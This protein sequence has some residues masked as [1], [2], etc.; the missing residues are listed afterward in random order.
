VS[1]ELISFIREIA[2]LIGEALH[3]FNTEEALH[4]NYAVQNVINALLRL[5]DEDLPLQDILDRALDLI[6]SFHDSSI[7]PRGCIFVLKQDQN[8]L[9]MRAQ[10]GVP[11]CAQDRCAEVAPGHCLCGRAA[12]EGVLQFSASVDERHEVALG[13]IPPH[14]HYCIPVKAEGR[15]LAVLCILLPD[16]YRR[17]AKENDSLTAMANTLGAIIS[18][19]RAEQLVR[20]QRDKLRTLSSELSLAE[21]KERK[22]IATALHDSVGQ[23]LALSKLKLGS[24][25]SLLDSDGQEQ[26]K[27]VSDIFEMSIQQLRTLTFELSPPILYELGLPAAI[28]WLGEQFEQHQDVMFHFDWSGDTVATD[29]ITSVLLFQSTRELLANVAKHAKANACPSTQAIFML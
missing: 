9:V 16:G 24:I 12:L 22:R 11:V 4:Q 26:L 8:V 13:S 19:Y 23:T 14:G 10:R 18:R 21:E 27:E 2:I 3:R 20:T 6:L 1:S 15:T 25:S 28:E 29:E 5:P 7:Q 17:S